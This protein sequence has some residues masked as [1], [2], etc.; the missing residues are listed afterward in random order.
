MIHPFLVEYICMQIKGKK[1]NNKPFK[2]WAILGINNYDLK[3]FGKRRAK[4]V[5]GLYYFI[6]NK[7]GVGVG[8]KYYEYT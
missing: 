2:S 5:N 4:Y 8:L 3:L 7:K 6:I 1:V